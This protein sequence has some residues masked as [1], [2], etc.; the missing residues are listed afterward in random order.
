VHPVF[1]VELLRPFK[2]T[3]VHPSPATVCEDGTV[4]WELESIVAVRGSGDKRRYRVRWTG[5][6]P[7]W[8]TWE[9]RKKLIE[10]APEEVARFEREGS[11]AT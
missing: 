5:F 2:G 7:E 11:F 6:G 3:G 1:H 9:P 4:Y 8:D 10:D